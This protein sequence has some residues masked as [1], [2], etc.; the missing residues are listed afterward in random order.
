MTHPLA[1]AAAERI[2]VLDGAMGTMIQR[3]DLGEEDFRAERFADH[4]S[5]LKGNN[6]LLSL[7]APRLIRQIHHD[8]LAAGAD[9]I[10]TNTFAAT[11]IA[12][13]DYGLEALCYEMNRASAAL[14]REAAAAFTDRPRF[15]AGILGPT[16]RTLSIS[17]DVND[18]GKRT[19]D[20]DGALASYKEAAKGLL[21]GG[22]DLLMVETVFDTLNAKAALRAVLELF[23]E[24]KARV[25]LLVSGTITDSSG[26][27][28]SGQTPEAFWHSLRHAGLFSVGLNCALGAREMRPFLQALAGVAEVPVSCHPNAGLPNAF[29]GYDEEPGE[30]ARRIAGWADEGLLNLVGGCCGTTPD[31]VRAIAAAV[32]GKTPRTPVPARKA[33]RLS[34]LEALN[35]D[36]DSLF[37]NIGERSNVTGSLRFARLI[38][39]GQYEEALSVARQQVE[40]GAQ[41]IDINMD[42]AM[43][44]A[45]A[46]MDRFT[47][48]VA[49][50]PEISRVPVVLDSSR[51]E[52]IEAGLKNLQGKCVVNSISLKEGEEEFLHHARQARLYGA[53]VIVM[54][55]DE[56]G[57][58]ESAERKVAICRRAHGLLTREAGFEDSDI[59]FDPNIFA[60]A[61]GIAEH[62]RLALEY[63]EACRRLRAEFPLCPIS[64][65]V[66]NLSFS[67]RGNDR[68]REAMHAAFLYHAISAGMSMGIVNAGQ[69]AVYEEIPDELLQAVEDVILCRREGATERLL[70]LAERYHG[71][72]RTAQ[73]E[74]AWREAP[75]AERLS[76]ALVKGINEFILEDTEEARLQADRPLEVIEGPLMA[77]MNHV[78]ELFGAGKMFLPQVVKS[79]RVMKQAVA[80]LLPWLEAEKEGGSSRGKILLATVKGDVHDIGKNIVGV[81]LG[82]NNFEVIDLGVMVPANRILDAAREHNVDII[83]LSGLITPSLEEMRQ[84]ASELQRA[85]M[86][87]PLL[88]GGATTSRLHTAVK[89]DPE[90]K[91]P[92]IHVKDASRAA[93]V[94]GAL[95]SRDQRTAFLEEHAREQE[96][97]RLSHGRRQAKRELLS[98]DEARGRGETLD[99]RASPPTA[100]A[101][102]GIQVLQ[103]EL[104]ELRPFIDWSPFFHTWE[105]KGRYPEILEAP[106]IGQEAR[107]LYDDAQVLLDQLIAEKWLQA[108]AVFGLFPAARQ[109]EDI[110]LYTDEQ[111][112]QVQETLYC[113]RQQ[114]GGGSAAAKSSLADFVAPADSGVPDWVG[115]FAVCAGF[116]LDERAAAFESRGDDYNSILLKSLADR[117][118]EA[119]AEWLHQCIRRQEWGYAPDEALDNE[120]LIAETYRGIRPAPGYPACPDHSEKKTLF[121]LLQVRERIGLEL[122]ESFAMWPAS[123]VSGWYFAHPQSHYFGIGRI[124][125]DQLQDYA[126][127]KGIPIDEAARLLAPLLD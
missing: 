84:V 63:I 88:I 58:A 96:E 115:A 20:W 76:H 50:E 104:A 116:G 120:A 38:R 29:G 5:E 2:L 65:G 95:L 113:L 101:R 45:V 72:G 68:V 67:F 30:M 22:A 87:Q 13:A 92:V 4:P 39:K 94:A 60:I 53:A 26:R 32:R 91:D 14:A 70:E 86:K 46:A 48:L 127:R 42:D 75:V 10:E 25:P 124:G 64:G 18:P 66:S 125:K 17:P 89:I 23:A 8:Y 27:T 117:L 122:T 34:G 102:S 71:E 118:A 51:W 40:N 47:K 3:H 36:A 55:F 9:I 37:A 77:G 83:G 73:T 79:A 114:H 112:G 59:L 43:L 24:R 121:R 126:R 97:L 107:K 49:T 21:D 62:D 93:G 61:T 44:D 109:G 7:T 12:Q 111:R 15:V 90:R 108:R 31:H 54:A 82:C 41:L 78:G 6:D 80:H 119:A 52:V 100:P 123:A 98:W 99:F 110:L 33:T 85:S 81:V 16:N 57:Q 74:L 56:E 35:L 105:M 69:L 28:L 11:S 19:L 1:T 106:R 103:P